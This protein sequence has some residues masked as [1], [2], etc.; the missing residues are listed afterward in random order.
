MLYI[1]KSRKKNDSEGNVTRHQSQSQIL[2][3]IKN[4]EI[5]LWLARARL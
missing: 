2:N 3:E 5:K 4:K 1:G